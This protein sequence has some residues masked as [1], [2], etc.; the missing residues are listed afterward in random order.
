MEPVI[1]VRDLTY[2]YPGSAV[3][4]VQGLTF[5]VER[6]E[7]FG[8]LGPN[9]AGKSTTQKVLIGIQKGYLGSVEI[10]GRRFEQWGKEYYERI[11]VAFEFPNHYLKLTALENLQYFGALYSRGTQDPMK[12]LAEVGLAK[13][14]Q[15]RVERFSKGMRGRLTLAR[16]LLN[17]PE[18][19]FLDEPTSGLDPVMSRRVRKL[20]L[21]VREAGATVFLTTHSMTVADELC[22]RV[23]FIVDGTLELIDAPRSLKL[24]YGRRLVRVEFREDGTLVQKD[25]SL[26]GLAENEEFLSALRADRLETIHTQETTLEDIFIQVTGKSLS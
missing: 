19:L 24:R 15:K 16:A 10:F 7:I 12:V 11:G 9:G 6:G 25:F 2:S 26:E 22:D 3:P 5:R 8:F 1:D 18:L 17:K 21:D 4:A 20:I 13:D 14:A 23:A